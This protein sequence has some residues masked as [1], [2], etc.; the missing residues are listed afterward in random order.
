[1]RT[2]Y[3]NSVIHKAFSVPKAMSADEETRYLARI[4]E[5]ALMNEKYELDAAR[6]KGREEARE[7]RR[8]IVLYC[9]VVCKCI[10]VLNTNMFIHD[11][12]HRT[13]SKVL[14]PVISQSNTTTLHQEA[15]NPKC[16]FRPTVLFFLNT[17]Y[18]S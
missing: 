6:R 12:Y 14:L 7:E 16:L 10:S 9:M 8:K 13:A 15:A 18:H 11:L 5:E 17:K 4:R 1:M 2:H 3:K